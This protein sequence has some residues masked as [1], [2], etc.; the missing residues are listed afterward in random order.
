[1]KENRLHAG[2]SLCCGVAL[3]LTFSNA[4][5]G[6]YDYYECTDPD[7]TLTSCVTPCP[8]GQKQRWVTDSAKPPS[9]D[10]RHRES[11]SS[12]TAAV[13]HWVDKILWR[14]HGMDARTRHINE[15]LY[16]QASPQLK[17]Y[18]YSFQVLRTIGS[19]AVLSTPRNYDVPAFRLLGALY[20]H[21]DVKNPGN[22]AFLAAQKTLGE[23]QSEARAI[24]LSQPGISC[25][26]WQLD[27]PWLEAHSINVPDE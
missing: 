27:A 12:L 2:M 21:M 9:E 10:P 6:P 3:L 11:A 4:M 14:I 1:M 22:P 20:P 7:G 26:R 15:A 23:V 18:P 24:V 16:T 5:A 17:T 25:V 19:T 13:R 8:E